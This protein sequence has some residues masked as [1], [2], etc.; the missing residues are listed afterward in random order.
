MNRHIV[1]MKLPIT[2]AFLVI[3]IESMEECPSLTQKLMQIYCSTC[4]IILNVMATQYTCSLNG[5]YRPN[6]PVQWSHQYSHMCIL[7]HSPWPPGYMDVTQTVPIILTMG[8]L[9][10]DRPCIPCSWIGRL[11]IIKMSKLPK[12]IYRFNAIP[13][14]MPM[15]YFKDIEEAFQKFI[16]NHKQPQIAT[17]IL[18]NKN[19]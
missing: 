14:K 5:I 11:N 8:G 2:V 13:V 4:S 6:W 12:V 7:V 16:W 9:F 18:R 17:A 15:T 10:L 1:M 3:L 19:K